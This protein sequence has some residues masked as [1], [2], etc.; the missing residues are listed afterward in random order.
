M[1][2]MLLLAASASAADPKWRLWAVAP[3]SVTNDKPITIYGWIENVGDVPLSGNVTVTHTFPAGISPVDA[4]I[5]GSFSGSSCQL[6]NQASVCDVNVD[7]LVPGGQVRF[8]Y[9]G[10]SNRPSPVPQ[11]AS[12]TL[13]DVID[14]S[15]GG[16]V[17]P[18]SVEQSMTVDAPEP[19]TVKQFAM[20]LTGLEGGPAAQAGS[21][22]DELASTV[23]LRSVAV[24]PFGTGASAL[25]AP[26]GHLRDT[27]V[28]VPAG[29]VGNP[30]ATPVK[31]TGQQLAEPSPQTSG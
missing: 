26:T 2:M 29:F 25:I 31:C 4:F 12:G 18:Q 13:L 16:M 30:S 14:V 23:L 9:G 20:E 19:F 21:T 22:P 6:I 15:G 28:H 17:D 8:T 27:V 11:G 10:D 24:D 1:V 5:E 3:D 7:G